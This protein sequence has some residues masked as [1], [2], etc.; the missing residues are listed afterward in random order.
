MHTDHRAQKKRG[1]PN[2]TYIT[3]N[4]RA[5][6]K[7]YTLEVPTE[8]FNRWT[9]GK[10]IKDCF[11]QLSERDKDFLIMNRCPNCPYSAQNYNMYDGDW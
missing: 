9:V 11:P 7:E 3:G 6:K 2:S 4:C 10:L 1:Y 5:C 8:Q